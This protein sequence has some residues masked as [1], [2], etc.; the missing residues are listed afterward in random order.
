MFNNFN[1]FCKMKSLKE[2]KAAMTAAEMNHIIGG[3]NEMA[4]DIDL[5]LIE[6]AGAGVRSVSADCRPC[7][8]PSNMNCRTI[9]G[10]IAWIGGVITAKDCI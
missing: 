8:M 10:F 5:E 2:M 9:R 7:N 6:E 4:S 1:Y 3:N